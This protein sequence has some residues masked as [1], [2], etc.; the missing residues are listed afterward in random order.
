VIFVTVGM[1]LPF[2][3]LVLAV[4]R[5]AHEAGRSGEVFAQI[6]PTGSAPRHVEYARKLTAA[7]FEKR[8]SGASLLVAHA[9]IG[10]IT[11]A[12]ERGVPTA[13]M[14]RR[15]SLGEH[16]NDHQVATC[17]ELG[18]KYGIGVA[19]D[20]EELRE[21]LDRPRHTAPANPLDEEPPDRARLVRFINDFCHGRV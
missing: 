16:R 4:D 13:V 2:D 1:Q 12:L 21:I 7:E 15:A 18:T 5:W 19:S 17:V 10:T 20:E 11:Q 8:L 14:P 3:R 6:G 9:G